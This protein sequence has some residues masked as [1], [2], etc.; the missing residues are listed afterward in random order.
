M[1]IVLTRTDD[2]FI[3]GQVTTGWAR[4][5]GARR[6]VL[7]NDGIAADPLIQKL[8]RLSA[9]PGV[10][11]VFLSAAAA[12]ERLGGEGFG[13]EPFFLLVESPADLVPLIQAGLPLDEVSL[14]NLRFEPGR[15]KIANWFF[16]DERQVAALRELDARGVRLNAQWMIGQETIH[17]NE[18]L[19]RNR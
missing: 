1:K 5:V 11:V 16:V 17:V 4:K 15:R 13:D 3:H 2:R 7:V 6:I 8:Q 18:W 19:A 9:G 14:G 12:V 10:E